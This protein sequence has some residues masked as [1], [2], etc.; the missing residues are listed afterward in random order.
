TLFSSSALFPFT[1]LFRSALERID[2]A[3]SH[4]DALRSD[5]HALAPPEHSDA[6]DAVRP[7]IE[8]HAPRWLDLAVSDPDREHLDRHR[9]RRVEPLLCAEIADRC[10]HLGDRLPLLATPLALRR[11]PRHWALDQ[12]A[13]VE[14]SCA[15][16]AHP[17]SLR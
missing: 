9:L 5:L 4:L 15:D 3:H 16:A 8:H 6:S 2:H 17:T 13:S 1:T 10:R 11:H 14:R 7:P 12:D